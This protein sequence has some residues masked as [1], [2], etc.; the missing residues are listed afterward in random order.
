[1]HKMAHKYKLISVANATNRRLSNIQQ[2]NHAHLPRCFVEGGTPNT[3]LQRLGSN[4][5][6]I[7]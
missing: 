1:M 3:S 6:Q 7:S 2:L 4:C 5:G